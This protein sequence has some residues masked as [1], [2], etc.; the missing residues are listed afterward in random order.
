M[1]HPWNGSKLALSG[2]FFKGR[3]LHEYA[4]TCVALGLSGVD[5]WPWNV[6]N[7]SP[8]EAATILRS[9][10]LTVMSVNIPGNL[11]RLGQD[12]SNP[13]LRSELTALMDLAV[14]CETKYLQM[15]CSSPQSGD[16]AA[17]ARQ[18]AKAIQGFR[19]M[20]G[21][22]VGILLENNL[23]QRREDSLGLNPS[24]DVNTMVA[25][26]QEIGQSDVRICFDAANAVAIGLDPSA[27]FCAAR[28]YIG[29]I[30]VKDCERFSPSRHVGRKES[31]F[32]LRDFLNG[33]FLPTV[34][35]AGAVNWSALKLEMMR[36]FSGDNQMW[37][38]IDPF[39]DVS[40]LDWWCIQSVAAWRELS[41]V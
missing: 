18:L 12:M 33:E 21:T 22:D 1:T 15:Y 35:G 17:S 34:V 40:L 26:I 4:Q 39:I 31:T 37:A 3:N 14:A 38:V 28:D 19:S 2:Y 30:H 10:S 5:L 9:Y 7:F 16:L 24:R 29:L 32:L 23:D 13:D 36:H 6:N 20:V 25:A 41:K 27:Q 11:F 8:R